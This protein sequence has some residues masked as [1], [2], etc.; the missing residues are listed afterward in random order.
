MATAMRTEASGG[1]ICHMFVVYWSLMS[2]MM[3][4]NPGRI[5]YGNTE[6]AFTKTGDGLK[7]KRLT[8]K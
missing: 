6:L 5:S 2:S 3:V 8:F 1:L 4:G 7:Q